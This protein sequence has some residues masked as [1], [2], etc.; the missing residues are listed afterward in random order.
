MYVYILREG[1]YLIR[2]YS[3]KAAYWKLPY[4][5][6]NAQSRR[7]P[8]TVGKVVTKAACTSETPQP[9]RT[10]PGSQIAAESAS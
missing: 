7:L 8:I 10:P 1:D 9:T 5:T 6:S 4:R 3:R 2:A